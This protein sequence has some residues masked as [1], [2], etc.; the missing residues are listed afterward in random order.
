MI[1]VIVLDHHGQPVRHA[2]VHISWG[3][4][5]F[6]DTFS[7]AT[8]GG[9]GAAYINTGPG[10]GTISVDGREV[11]RGYLEGQIIVQV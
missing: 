8:T 10:T 3:S 2:R 1:T 9:D 4:G 6:F 5:G 7:N 11:R